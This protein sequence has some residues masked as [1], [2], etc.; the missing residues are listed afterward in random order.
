VSALIRACVILLVTVAPAAAERVLLADADP[1][2]QR[3]VRATLAPWRVEVVV[4]ADVRP[5]DAAQAQQIG[6]ANTARFVV[7]R[8][9]TDLVVF[10]RERGAAEHRGAP[11][12]ALD[13]AS[14]AAAALTVKTLMRLSSPPRD[15]SP[16]EVE[17][18]RTTE[19]PRDT[20][21]ELRAQG[22]IATRA[23][24]G[25]SNEVGGRASLAVFLK[26][27]AIPLRFGL[28][29]ELGT[30]TDVQGAGFKGSWSDWSVLG[31]ASWSFVLHP[32]WVLEPF[33]GA[34]VTRSN[35]DGS[36]GMMER[37]ERETLP[38]VRAGLM[39]RLPLG[40]FS[41]GGAVTFDAML[42]TPTYTKE[43]G[44]AQVFEV[45][46]TALSLGFVVAADLGR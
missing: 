13:P 44:M 36:E 24:R 42:G 17:P 9:G 10:D 45:P 41:I 46:E 19:P 28:A 21:V 33:A 40:V 12:G 38:M 20:G 5:R 30:D 8:D 31:L 14:A 25:A 3:A 18:P 22:G 15:E 37:H 16:R 27:A 32:R 35:L 23:T 6:D 26:P 34:G 39:L 11:S 7:W 29:A 1:E 43:P 2:L 4:E